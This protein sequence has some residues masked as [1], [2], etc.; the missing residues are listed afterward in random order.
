MNEDLATY[1]CGFL[2]RGHYQKMTNGNICLFTEEG[3]VCYEGPISAHPMLEECYQ[4]VVNAET[5]KDDEFYFL[6]KEG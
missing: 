5:S 2:I 6:P 4:F 3:V 1:L